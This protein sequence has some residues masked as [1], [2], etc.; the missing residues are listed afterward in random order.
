MQVK[1]QQLELDMEQRTGSKFG[2]ECV[3]VV[4]CHPAY[5]TYMQSTSCEIPGWIKNWC[6]WTVVLEKTFESPLDSKEIQL[7]N[8]KENQPWIFTGRTDA[9]AEAP[10]LWPLD[11]KSWLIG[12]DPDA[13]K[14]WR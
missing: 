6:F 11:E 8:P 2:K 7:V 13:E 5:L 4:Y 14:D 12:K 10:V 3:K 9:D 1:K